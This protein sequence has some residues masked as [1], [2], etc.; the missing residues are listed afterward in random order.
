[1]SLRVRK[2][3]FAF[4]AAVAFALVVLGCAPARAE[5]N[6]GVI[7][8]RAAAQS[9]PGYKQWESKILM[10]KKQREQE[11]TNYIRQQF[12]IPENEEEANLTDE[13]KAQ[14]SD[15]LYQANEQF[16]AEIEPE[17]E[18]Q[19][20]AVHKDIMAALEVVLEG[21]EINIVLDSNVVL[22]GGTDLTEAVIAELQKIVPPAEAPGQ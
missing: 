13:Q 12:N 15:I 18:Q 8:L 20:M 14:I 3:Y 10:L 19:L 21:S 9:H 5:G 17:Q 7:D 2:V 6:I 4:A 1:M 22:I 16:A 11:V